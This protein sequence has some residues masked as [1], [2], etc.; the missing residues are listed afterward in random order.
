[1]VP[2]RATVKQSVF[3]YINSERNSCLKLGF[4]LD[5]GLIKSCNLTTTP[6]KRVPEVTRA[7]NFYQKSIIQ[8]LSHTDPQASLQL[9]Q[10]N[11]ECRVKLHPI[12]RSLFFTRVWVGCFRGLYLNVLS[13]PPH[14]AQCS[15]NKP[16]DIFKCLFYMPEYITKD[17][18][19]IYF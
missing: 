9:N 3:W 11:E 15:L 17:V 10:R 1:M 13:G 18:S 4:I 8:G 14:L 5:E 2:H 12:T 6:G 7:Q 19:P 16:W